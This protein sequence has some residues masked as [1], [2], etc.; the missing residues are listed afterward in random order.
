MSA[1]VEAFLD[2][3]AAE[4]GSAANTL[5]AYRRDLEATEVLV[6]DLAAAERYK[7]AGLAGRWATLAPTTVARKSSALRQFFGFAVE[8]GWRT[9]D[10]SAALPRPGARRR[11][12]KILSH[13]DIERLFARAELEAENGKPAAIRQLALLELLYGSGLRATELVSLPLSAVPRDAPL[14]TVMGKGGQARMVPVSER[15]RE[16]L[17]VWITVREQGS[18]YLFPSRGK[19]LSRVRLFQLLKELAV[20]A[21]IPP[22]S[23]SPHVLRHAF[24]TH[25]LEGGADLRVLQTLLGHAD[26]ATTQIYTHVDAARLVELVN[27]RHPLAQSATSD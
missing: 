3:M 2:M 17:N 9:D 27:A 22:E 13:E 7:I 15:A 20:R 25:L 5:A 19:H 1:A 11:L 18:Q 23:I 16:A 10:P 14:L 6:G 26:I 24:A 8:E 12:P 4:R 21:E